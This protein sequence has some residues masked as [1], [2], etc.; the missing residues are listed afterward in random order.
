MIVPMQVSVAQLPSVSIFHW[1]KGEMTTEWICASK[2]PTMS[3]FD[4]G[5]HLLSGLRILSFLE[6]N[7]S[8]SLSL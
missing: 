5:L 4:P 3:Q 2:E 1:Q 8:D 6:Q 7:N